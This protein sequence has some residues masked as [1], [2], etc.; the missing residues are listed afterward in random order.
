MVL[1]PYIGF[2]VIGAWYTDLFPPGYFLTTHSAHL[3]Y[4]EGETQSITIIIR[5]KTVFSF[6]FRNGKRIPNTA[7]LKIS[8]KQ[9][10]I[11]TTTPATQQQFAGDEIMHD[12][13]FIIAG[14]VGIALAV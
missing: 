13:I 8:T 14:K 3:F 10:I 4:L 11:P 6:F 7:I 2:R 5:T 12:G 9:N 1:R